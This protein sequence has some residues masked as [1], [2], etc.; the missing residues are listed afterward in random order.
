MTLSTHLAFLVIVQQHTM[1]DMFRKSVLN[2]LPHL[3]PTRAPWADESEPIEEIDEE[4]EQL[5]GIGEFKPAYAACDLVSPKRDFSD[6]W[7][8]NHGA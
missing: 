8:Q 7:M 2:K 1:S 4:D 5:D 3:P 6:V